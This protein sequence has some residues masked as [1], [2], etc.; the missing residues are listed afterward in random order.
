MRTTRVRSKVER[1]RSC[2]P[3]TKTQEWD[4][5]FFAHALFVPKT[6]NVMGFSGSVNGT[7]KNP[8][9]LD[10]GFCQCKWALL[11]LTLPESILHK[12]INCLSQSSLQ[13]LFSLFLI[14]FDSTFISQFSVSQSF[15]FSTFG[16]NLGRVDCTFYI[17]IHKRKYK[18]VGLAKLP[19]Y[20]MVLLYP[21]SLWQGSTVLHLLSKIAYL[22]TLPG[23]CRC[24]RLPSGHRR[25]CS[26]R[27]WSSRS[28]SPSCSS[29]LWIPVGSHTC[30]WSPDGWS[31]RS[32]MWSRWIRP[33]SRRSE[34]RCSG[35]S[36]CRPRS[37]RGCLQMEARWHPRLR[38]AGFAWGRPAPGGTGSWRRN[39][40]DAEPQTWC[41][42]YWSLH[43][44]CWRGRP[45]PG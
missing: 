7:T 14:A 33:A 36:R 45:T 18:L 20:K 19:C 10:F 11:Q 9:F 21:T 16:F 32:L 17:R 4:S 31:G 26:C 12:S 22:W 34:V 37:G 30:R 24:I 41:W 39:R 25:L 29:S 28:W 23:T 40:R 35:R 3:L 43:P 15:F 6:P 42:G 1:S 38:R 2:A 13:V 44:W 27:G 5:G 8:G